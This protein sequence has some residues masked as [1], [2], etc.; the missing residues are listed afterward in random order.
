MAKPTK[1]A[2]PICI[3]LSIILGIGILF[4]LIYFN[5]M[6]IILA[7][8]PAVI[9][10][11]YR[12]EG[13]STRWASWAMLGVMIAEVI[14]VA[15]NLK[16]DLAQFLGLSGQY[17]S[18]HWVPFGEVRAIFPALTGVLALIL[19]FRTQGIYTR[20]LSVLIF[21][22]ALGIVFTVDKTL[23]K[24]LLRTVINEGMGRLNF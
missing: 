18:G 17:V 22:G 6:I 2:T 4:G 11:V 12:T 19:F 8:F 5:P 3:T 1:N 7:L 10:E 9:Y 15:F 13:D 14:V 16:F 21:I 24:E 20:W 23:F